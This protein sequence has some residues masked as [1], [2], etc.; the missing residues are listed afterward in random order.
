MRSWKMQSGNPASVSWMWGQGC[1]YGSL[2]SSSFPG[3]E[4]KDV[5]VESRSTEL[6]RVSAGNGRRMMSASVVSGE[7]SL[8]SCRSGSP[9]SLLSVS[10]G[11]KFSL[12]LVPLT[13]TKKTIVSCCLMKQQNKAKQ[14][15]RSI[16]SPWEGAAPPAGCPCA[17]EQQNRAQHPGVAA[18]PTQGCRRLHCQKVTGP[19]EEGICAPQLDVTSVT[20]R[21]GQSEK[22]QVAFPAHLGRRD[23]D[24][25]GCRGHSDPGRTR[26]SQRAVG[27]EFLEKEHLTFFQD[28]MHPCV[29]K[30]SRYCLSAEPR[31]RTTQ[32]SR[33]PGISLVIVMV[34]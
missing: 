17:V 16:I 19:V 9:P 4:I 22:I 7:A 27:A 1:A 13:E 23:R 6:I 8:S 25:W 11:Y 20:S 29:A 30:L 31:E 21:G 15:C 33:H 2:C 14:G 12:A 3:G 32:P 26:D 10:A 34:F 28:P 24:H 5:N 18:S